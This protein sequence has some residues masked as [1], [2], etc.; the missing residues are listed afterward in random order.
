MDE[1]I[2]DKGKAKHFFNHLVKSY[3]KFEEKEK[4]HEQLGKQIEKIKELSYS[5]PSKRSVEGAFKRLERL[6]EEVISLEKDI[7]NKG[8][9]KN[10]SEEVKERIQE[11]EEK[12][13]KY[14][15]LIEGR[16]K[17]VKALEEKIKKKLD[18]EKLKESQIK[19]MHEQITQKKEKI[20][21]DKT[22]ALRNKLYDLEERYYELKTQGVPESRLKLIK[23][24]IKKLKEIL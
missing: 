3:Q 19:E 17:K 24:K 13:D 2:Y 8:D 10:I 9:Q 6:M 23:E 16:K 5:Q 20:T 22:I 4:A 11:L 15:S 21:S 12:L 1:Q 7:L 14:T 18:S